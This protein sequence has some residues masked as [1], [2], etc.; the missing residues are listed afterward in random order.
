VPSETAV[1]AGPVT[2][3]IRVWA[4][5]IPAYQRDGWRFSH[6][7]MGGPSEQLLGPSWRDCWMVREVQD[8]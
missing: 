6:A 7:I 2:E 5:E 8:D 3:W 1:S 4:Y